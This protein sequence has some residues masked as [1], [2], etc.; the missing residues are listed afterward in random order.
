MLM[1]LCRC[2]C[3]CARAFC[4][5]FEHC[6]HTIFLGY[7][8]T[9]LSKMLF[10]KVLKLVFTPCPFVMLANHLFLLLQ[11]S[12]SLHGIVRARIINRPNNIP[13]P[14]C[15]YNIHIHS[16]MYFIYNNNKNTR[17]RNILIFQF[18]FKYFI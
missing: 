3:V 9:S 16:I 12:K 17:K 4:I 13:D 11:I 15:R 2:V 7:K 8:I 14:E 6:F 5:N 1:P 10:S 18:H